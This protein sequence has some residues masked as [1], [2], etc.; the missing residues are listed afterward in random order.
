MT[1]ATATPAARDAIKRAHKERAD[2][3]REIWNWM[4]G[5]SSR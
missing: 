5:R 4:F 1:E 3:T 2:A